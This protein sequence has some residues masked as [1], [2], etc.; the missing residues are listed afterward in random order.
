[1]NLNCNYPIDRFVWVMEL[2]PPSHS[3]TDW[4]GDSRVSVGGLRHFHGLMSFI[5]KI[6]SKP[7]FKAFWERATKYEANQTH[8]ERLTNVKSPAGYMAKYLTKALS[9]GYHDRERRIGFSHNFPKLI[10]N[11]EIKKGVYL[12]YDP[13]IEVIED[14]EFTEMLNNKRY[15]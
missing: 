13:R 11:L 2:T 9:S 5:D 8:F 6:P 7:E 4:K 1:M 12:P 10:S 3:Y 15:L 14:K